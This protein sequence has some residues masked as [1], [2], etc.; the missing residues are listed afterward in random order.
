MVT[1]RDPDRTRT[2][3]LEAARVEFAA[4]GGAGA[5]VDR[6]AAAAGVNKRMIYHYFGSK[7][8][9]YAAL[10]DAW[11]GQAHE[12]L[13]AG[14]AVGSVDRDLVRLLMWEALESG[15]RP[16]VREAERTAGWRSLVTAWAGARPA[17]RGEDASTAAHRALATLALALFPVAFPQLTRMIAGVS[18]GDA[19]YH[20]L[21]AAL[22]AFAAVPAEA[23]K[24]RYRLAPKVT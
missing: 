7:E 21:R 13:T 9:L 8:G 12:A 24:P 2:R 15:N 14:Q 19:G 22:L 17:P 6:I 4:V 11:L 10:L 1:K 3:I 23:A 16:V 20:A 5:R 18:A